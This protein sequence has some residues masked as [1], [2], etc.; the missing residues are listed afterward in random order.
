MPPGTD[1][2][3]EQPAPTDGTSAE[4]AQMDGDNADA[5]ES[6]TEEKQGETESAVTATP[7]QMMAAEGTAVPDDGVELDPS[8]QPTSD[9]S[10]QPTLEPSMQDPST[11]P[12]SDPSMQPTLDP[13]TQPTPDLS[14]PATP[15]PSTQPTPEGVLMIDG[16]P[17]LQDIIEV[18]EPEEVAME[19]DRDELVEQV[20]LAIEERDR[21]QGL[22]SQV[23][24]EIA[25]YLAR[26]KVCP[27]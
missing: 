21:L 27:I 8:I 23:Q 26:K 19:E 16:V 17:V 3:L 2:E 25:E 20:R 1:G 7:E 12:T 6:R 18:E 14:T 9:P 4:Q 22:S 5:A 24:H 13:S 10:T 15:D 11:Q